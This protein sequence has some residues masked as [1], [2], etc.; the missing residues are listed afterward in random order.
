MDS[1]LAF[2]LI[3]KSKIIVRKEE[4]NLMFFSSLVGNEKVKEI[5]TNTIQNG[6]LSHSYMFLGIEGIGKKL[7]AKELA[8]I[9]LCTN[10]E[11][12]LCNKCKSCIEFDSENNPDLYILDN[13]K[14]SIKI[15]QIRQMQ[16]KILEKPI[17]SNKKVY[18]INNADNMTKEARKLFTK[19]IRRA[20]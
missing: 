7:F 2:K 3:R 1:F 5:L 20:T 16:S 10:E 14:E 8:K 12:K 19:D 18:I 6:K 17:I 15:E 11:Q 4:K 13:G 9:I